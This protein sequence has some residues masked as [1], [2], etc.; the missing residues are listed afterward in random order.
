MVLFN[1]GWL[2][3]EDGR[4]WGM[5]SLTNL[6]MKFLNFIQFSSSEWL[7]WSLMYSLLNASV[8]FLISD[9]LALLYKGMDLGLFLLMTGL[10][11]VS[12]KTISWSEMPGITVMF[13]NRP[14][15]D[16]KSKSRFR[17]SLVGDVW[18]WS[19]WWSRA[20]FIIPS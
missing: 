5:Q 10:I 13:F 9:Q 20:M 11:L 7:L 8:L 3:L 17:F 12:A 19:M 18:T 4:L 6:L 15:C 1:H 2:F 14:G 16:T